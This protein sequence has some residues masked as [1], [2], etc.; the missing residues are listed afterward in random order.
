MPRVKNVN[1]ISS[2]TCKCGCWLNHWERYSGKT[3][4]YCAEQKCIEEDVVG[5]C[6]RKVNS[7]DQNLYIVPLCK[8]H[9][10]SKSELDIVGTLVTANR[11]VTCEEVNLFVR[12]RLYI[13]RILPS[14]L[15][16]SK[17]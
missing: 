2:I 10:V 14:R 12:I 3:A 16:F 15:H 1:G 13:S 7:S 17:V 9:N 11:E 4:N 6:V 5:A 8:I